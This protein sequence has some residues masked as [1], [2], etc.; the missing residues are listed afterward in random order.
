MITPEVSRRIRIYES[1]LL[2]NTLLKLNNKK[3]IKMNIL[4]NL[5][6]K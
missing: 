1:L 2:F 5:K 4:K 6:K 3:Y